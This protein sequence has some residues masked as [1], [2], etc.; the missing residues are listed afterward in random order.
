MTDQVANARLELLVFSDDVTVRRQV[1][2]GV[3][4]RPAKGLPL[5]KWTEAATAEGVR[6]AVKDRAQEGAAPFDALILDAETKKLGGMG[7]EGVA[8]ALRSRP[9]TVVPAG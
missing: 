5:V 4:R 9:G 6:M 3:G 2:E 1:K 8:K 7:L